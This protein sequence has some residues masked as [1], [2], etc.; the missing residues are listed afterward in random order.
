MGLDWDDRVSSIGVAGAGDRHAC[1]KEGI[2]GGR[3]WREGAGAGFDPGT[4]KEGRR[5]AVS[6]LSIL[7]RKAIFLPTGPIRAEL[8][9]S[10]SS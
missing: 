8:E 1:R 7:H 2:S 10:S 9:L 4:V 5:L 6:I 3:G